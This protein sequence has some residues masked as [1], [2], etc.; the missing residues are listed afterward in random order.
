MCSNLIYV[1]TPE[2]IVIN[3]IKNI[4]AIMFV[5]TISLNVSLTFGT[6]YLAMS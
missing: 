4:I 3:Y 5:P 2:A 1:I 6:V